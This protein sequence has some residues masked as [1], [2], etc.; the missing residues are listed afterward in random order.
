VV[1]WISVALDQAVGLQPVISWLMAG[2]RRDLLRSGPVRG[3]EG[4]QPWAVEEPGLLAERAG[5]LPPR[6]SR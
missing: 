5:Q 1:C 4:V 6:R 2:W 3:G